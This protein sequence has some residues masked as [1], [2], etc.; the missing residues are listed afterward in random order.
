MHAAYTHPCRAE[1]GLLTHNV[2]V[3]GQLLQ[4]TNGYERLG[5]DQY[6]AHIL[7]HRQGSHP[8]PIR[9]TH[10]HIM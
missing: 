8:T 5:A 9:Y 3:E 1:V 4:S 7:I 6:G 10:M 2:V